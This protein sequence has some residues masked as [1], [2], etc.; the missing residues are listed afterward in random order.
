MPKWS[1]DGTKLAFVDTH[2]VQVCELAGQQTETWYN[3]PEKQPTN[4]ED[5]ILLLAHSASRDLHWHPDGT[6]IGL[7]EDAQLILIGQSGLLKK[8][9]DSTVVSFAGWSADGKR[10]AYVSSEP[11]PYSNVP[12]ATLLIPNIHSRSAV[13]VT[14]AD[15]EN[16]GKKLISGVRATFLN[17]SRS[18]HKLSVWLTVE[19]PYHLPDDGLLGMRP[20]DPAA[21]ID[22]ETGQLDW[23]PVNGTE[24]AQIGHFELRA[25]RIEAALRRFDEAAVTL[26]ADATADWIFFRAITLQKAGRTMEANEALKRFEPPSPPKNPPGAPANG[27]PQIGNNGGVNPA[28]SEVI[29]IRDRFAVEAFISLDLTG[30]AIEYFQRE[31]KEAKTDVERL[32]ATIVLCQLHLLTDRRIEYAELAVNQLL[33]LAR[34]V[35]DNAMTDKTAITGAV[36]LTMLPLA[37]GEFSSSFKKELLRQICDKISNWPQVPDDVDFICQHIVRTMGQ[38]LRDAATTKNA[39]RRLVNHPALARWNMNG[40]TFDVEYLRQFRRTI[41]LPELLRGVF[42]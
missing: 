36:A 26:T 21:I 12:W 32:S 19:P 18:D 25:G 41:M 3:P 38:S 6:R 33:P 1:P 7:I 10:L 16:P 30:E 39:E 4:T 11:L 23:L 27:N 14:D 2:R 17:W 8:I 9:T 15:G 34:R 35:L 13:W 40:D 29:S 24:Q 5:A 22:P 37:V 31:L 28:T 20:G 42:G